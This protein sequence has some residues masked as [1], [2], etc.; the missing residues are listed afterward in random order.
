M[1]SNLLYILHKRKVVFYVNNVTLSFSLRCFDETYFLL[2]LFDTK[3][4]T[5]CLPRKHND[6]S[7]MV[8]LML[9]G[10]FPIIQDKLLVF[11]Q[12]TLQMMKNSSNAITV[13]FHNLRFCS[14]YCGVCFF[15]PSLFKKLLSLKI[16]LTVFPSVTTAMT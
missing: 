2:M 16:F 10:I 13:P 3:N 12:L 9:V 8:Y 15:L 5:L 14:F 11:V 7:K 6:P 4:D 1:T